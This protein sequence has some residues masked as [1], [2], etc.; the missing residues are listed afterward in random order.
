MFMTMKDK[1]YNKEDQFSLILLD[2]TNV[3]LGFSMCSIVSSE[4]RIFGSSSKESSFI[5]GFIDLNDFRFCQYESSLFT[6]HLQLASIIVDK[7][8]SIGYLRSDTK[9][10]CFFIERGGVIIGSSSLFSNIEGG[11]HSSSISF[12]VFSG[13][14]T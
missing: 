5:E 12:L 9:L 1:K 3:F 2:E 6:S 4:F 8:Y 10:M 13:I 11:S 14:Q 7:F